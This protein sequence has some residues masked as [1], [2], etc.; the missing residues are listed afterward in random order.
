MSATNNTEKKFGKVIT[1]ESISFTDWDNY[2]RCFSNWF[3]PKG[4][5]QEI[6][7]YYGLDGDITLSQI[8]DFISDLKDMTCGHGCKLPLLKIGQTRTFEVERARFWDNEGGTDDCFILGKITIT[9]T[10]DQSTNA[11]IEHINKYR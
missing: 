6:D 11:V 4:F 2:G 7:D 3:Q 5:G 8:A 10:S 1:R 9:R